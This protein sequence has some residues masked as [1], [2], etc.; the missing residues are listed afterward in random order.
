M[1]SNDTTAQRSRTPEQR[2]AA[3][4]RATAKSVEQ[5]ATGNLP[6]LL[7]SYTNEDGE[8]RSTWSVMSR[9]RGGSTYLVDATV[10]GN[11]ITTLCDC[12]AENICWHRAHIRGAILGDVEVR[13]G[14]RAEPDPW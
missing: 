7:R 10:D 11:G 5:V 13:D 4:D 2:Q 1:G 14:R 8:A 6:I 12:P 9:T 3:I